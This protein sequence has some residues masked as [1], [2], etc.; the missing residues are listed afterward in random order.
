MTAPGFV[1]RRSR[2]VVLLALA[3]S[4]QLF[5]CRDVEPV[6]ASEKGAAGSSVG[7]SGSSVGAS[8]AGGSAGAD[9]D[10][11]L[12]VATF[13]TARFF[14][15]VCDSSACGG[16]AFEPAVSSDQLDQKVKDLAGGIRA[17]DAGVVLLEEVETQGCLDALAAKLDGVYVTALVAETGSP[18]SVD[19]AVLARYPVVEVRRHRQDPLVLEDGS[20]STFSREFFEVRLSRPAGTFT[21][22][23]SHF[24]S[25]RNDDPAR[26]RAE[27]LRAR[28]IVLASHAERPGELMVW[29]GDLNDHPLSP[30]FDAI[31]E[32]GDLVR[33]VAEDLPYPEDATFQFGNS[34]SAID[35]LIVPKAFASR[36]VTGTAKVFRGTGSW[37]FASSDH[38]AL[39]ATFR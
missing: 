15:T 32:G 1:P 11:D 7:A 2:G 12:R 13:N 25:K 30:D 16:D 38:A 4:L 33:V 3:A 10:L 22:F 6:P 39:R 9:A 35:H 37:G 20:E 31:F 26:R 8:G 5:A 19:V 21:V 24:R 27:G 36:Y 17:L 28:Q 29:G 18:A 14:D 34:R 23:A